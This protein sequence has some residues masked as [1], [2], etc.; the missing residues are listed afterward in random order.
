MPNEVPG[1]THRA[2]L[3]ALRSD[4][5]DVL[6]AALKKL[7]KAISANGDMAL[8]G[9]DLAVVVGILVDKV[10][11]LDTAIRATPDHL[12]PED[13]D[14][15]IGKLDEVQAQ[16]EGGERRKREAEDHEREREA[17]TAAAFSALD[18]A[19]ADPDQVH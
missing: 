14:R 12:T 17:S 18:G 19:V 8:R 5:H 1:L 9:K 16:V 2:E 7:R 6:G 13:I 3:V 4:V 11:K 10:P 15:L